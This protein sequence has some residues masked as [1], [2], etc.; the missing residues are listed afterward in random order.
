MYTIDDIA[1]FIATHNR[2]EY[3]KQTM[4]SFI[5]QSVQP[6]KITVL[7]NESVDDTEQVVAQYKKYNFVYEKTFGKYGNFYKAQEN[8]KLNEAKYVMIFHDDDLLH[9]EFFEKMLLALNSIDEPPALL[10]ST[11]SWFPVNSMQVNIPM[12]RSY[13]LPNSYL[14]PL[15]LNNDYIV[16]NDSKEMVHL[17]LAA[18]N[19]PYP[20]INPC[21]CS[22][23]YRKDIF[24]ARVP[25]NDIYGKIDDIPLMI[26]CAS[27]GKVV[28]LADQN[29]VFHRTHRLRDG[30]SVKSGNTLEQSLNW[31]RAFTK[32]MNNEDREN[33]Q[34]LVYMISYLYP[35]I[36]HPDTLREYP[37]K[38][39]IEELVSKRYA[40]EY[41]KQIPL[42]S[43]Q[44]PE[45]PVR[46]FDVDNAIKN[47]NV[48]K[49]Q[50][51]KHL[52]LL[53]RLFS[54]R[55]E[56][57]PS[58]KKKKV[59]YLFFIKIGLGLVRRKHV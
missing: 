36:S 4:D 47:F 51:N 24:L 52:P 28:I 34:K 25:L 12:V 46:I 2:S 35:L 17:I 30:Y 32:H 42:S 38:R 23:L 15:P 50:N 9:P 59:L 33:Y 53:E 43:F 20:M 57:T 26:D 10:M 41:I 13:E 48:Q 16:I 18:E 27:K 11:F 45:T 5:V 49:I 14:Y 44:P 7:D 40:P 22:A 37:L 19:P 54:I 39:F 58:G 3:L 6:N 56:W 29:A 55:N 31:I 1:V 21:I 8:I